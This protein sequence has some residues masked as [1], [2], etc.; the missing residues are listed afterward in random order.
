MLGFNLEYF[1]SDRVIAKEVY[2]HRIIEKVFIV[3]VIKLHKQ[4]CFHLTQMNL[5]MKFLNL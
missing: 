4:L 2:C 1:N 3:I 5:L